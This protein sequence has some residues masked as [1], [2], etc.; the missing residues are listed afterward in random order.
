MNTYSSH[1]GLGFSA[2]KIG[3]WNYA[4]APQPLVKNTFTAYMELLIRILKDNYYLRDSFYQMS[5]P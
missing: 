4:P 2:Q 5:E 3:G 1:L